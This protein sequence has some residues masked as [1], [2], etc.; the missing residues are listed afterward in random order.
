ML[1]IKICF[2]YGIELCD[3]YLQNANINSVDLYIVQT[4]AW[5]TFERS[6]QKN[7]GEA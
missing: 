7:V 2:I 6:P 3:K 1:N 5:K 4:F